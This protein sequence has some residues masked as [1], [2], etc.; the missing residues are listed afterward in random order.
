M[1]DQRLTERLLVA[2]DLH[3]TGVEIMRQNL[4]RRFPNESNEEIEGRLVA[5]LRTRPGAEYGDGVGRPRTV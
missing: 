1:R 5:W 4:R 2:L 3:E